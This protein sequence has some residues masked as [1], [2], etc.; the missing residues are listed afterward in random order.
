MRQTALS[1]RGFRKRN[2]VIQKYPFCE[3]PMF[4][5]PYIKSVTAKFSQ[6]K[7]CYLKYPDYKTPTETKMWINNFKNAPC[8]G[9][10]FGCF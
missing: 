6:I 1:Q 7:S 5:G 2:P 8:R 3:T 9:C 4:E 10:F